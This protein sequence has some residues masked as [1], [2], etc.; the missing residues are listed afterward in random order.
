MLL[1]SLIALSLMTLPALADPAVIKNVKAR[2]S[3]GLWTFDVTLLH[4]DFG[5]DDY[6]DAWRILDADGNVLGQRNLAHPHVNE[7]PFTRSLSGVRIPAGLTQVFVE[8]H[9]T[10]GGWR[11]G[12]APVSLP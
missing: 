10:Q 6:A 8:A 2:Q 11:S 5:W 1:R 12:K 4:S 9:D 3:G 7:Q